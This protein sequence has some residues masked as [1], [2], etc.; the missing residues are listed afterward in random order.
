LSLL[1]LAGLLSSCSNETGLGKIDDATGPGAPEIR[2]FPEVVEFG[3]AGRDEVLTGSFVI[4]NIGE[5]ELRVGPISLGEG[6]E[7]FTILTPPAE[8]AFGLLAEGSKTIAVAFTPLSANE[9]RGEALVFSND[10]DTSRVTVELIGVG[11][12][13]D[14]VIDPNPYD[15]GDRYIG[16]DYT[17]DISLSNAGMDVLTVSS[18]DFSG[19]GFTLV[20]AP[21]LPFDLQPAE[22]VW[23]HVNFDP[24]AQMDYE[25]ALTVISDAP[26]SPDRGVTLGSGRYVDDY[27]DI[28]EVPFDP[29]VDLMFV[30]DQSGSMDDDQ[31]NL[32][33]NFG[34]FISRLGSYT[35]DWQIV[36]VNGH[37]G[38]NYG[39]ILRS[40]TSGYADTFARAVAQG[41]Q[42]AWEGGAGVCR[43][44]CPLYIGNQGVQ[45]TDSGECNDGFMRSDALLHLVL[46]TDE[47]D[48]SPG[49][50]ST[51]VSSIQAKKGSTANTKISAIAGDYPYGCSSASAA[52]GVYEAVNATDGVFLSIC[53][54][55]WGAS[56]EELADASIQITD[57]ELSHTPDPATLEVVVD[58]S[59]RGGGWHYES[60]ENLV[61]FDTDIPTEGSTVE[62]TYYG[63]ANCD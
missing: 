35:T 1:P 51:Y 49:S 27:T 40:T 56:V 57:F 28:W 36:V 37:G 17:G 16:C 13:P 30:V 20:S 29:P 23:V 8:L 50:W 24:Q 48:Q 47:P 15:Y 6:S 53:A 21:T 52:T 42:S 63:L 55:D 14:L 26:G 60:A 2:V 7:S 54:A 9:V 4:T 10:R 39:G 34:T 12:I 46:V 43:G 3:E 38:C 44:E 5:G 58:G 41:S 19:T 25:A 22:G 33:R 11:L 32:A 59:R 18:I 62:I 61:V 31:A 45:V